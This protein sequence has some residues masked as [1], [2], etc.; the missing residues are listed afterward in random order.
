MTMELMIKTEALADVLLNA[1]DEELKNP[2]FDRQDCF[3]EWLALAYDDPDFFYEGDYI[4]V[5][6]KCRCRNAQDLTLDEVRACVTFLIRQMR[7]EY[8]PYSCIRNRSLGN[9]LKRLY[10]LTKEEAK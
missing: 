7:H 6:Q 4:G 9:C 10:E 5:Y 1:S 2:G 3:T 8:A